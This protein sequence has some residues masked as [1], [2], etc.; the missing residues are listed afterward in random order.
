VLEIG[1]HFGTSTSILARAVGS[2]GSAVGVDIGD[3]IIGQAKQRH[4]DVEFHV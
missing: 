1:C 4:P 2:S 3:S